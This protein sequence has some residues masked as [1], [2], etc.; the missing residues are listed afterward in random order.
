M[1]SE[2]QNSRPDDALPVS[3]PSLLTVNLQV[4]SPSVGVSRPLLFPGIVAATTIKQLKDK[5]RQTLPSRPTDENQRL[6]H[7]GRAIVRETDTLLDIFGLDA[8]SLP[9]LPTPPGRYGRHNRCPLL[10]GACV[11]LVYS[12]EHP[13]SKPSISSSARL[14]T[15]ILRLNL[16]LQF[17]ALARMPRL[18]LRFL[19]DRLLTSPLA[20][21]RP[22]ASLGE[23]MSKFP[24]R[25]RL[26]P[27]QDC[28]R[29]LQL[30]MLITPRH[31]NSITRI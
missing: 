17:A 2:P 23:L 10:T 24:H 21:S 16:R 29:L 30:I 20:L 31:S 25:T 7:R 18:N 15:L 28:P 4:V 5:I 26:P 27:S 14:T 19:R 8:V 9:L 12:S 22:Q 13:I 6:I 1:A 11:S 3:S